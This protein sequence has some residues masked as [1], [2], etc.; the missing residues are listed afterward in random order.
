VRRWRE[1]CGL[2]GVDLGGVAE[3]PPLTL[4]RGEFVEPVLS[5]T[6]GGGFEEPLTPPDT[7]NEVTTMGNITSSPLSSETSLSLSLGETDIIMTSGGDDDVYCL[8]PDFFYNVEDMTIDPN[9]L[10]M[11]MTPAFLNNNNDNSSP[12]SSSVE[13]ILHFGDDAPLFLE[14]EGLVDGTILPMT[15]EKDLETWD[16]ELTEENSPLF[17]ELFTQEMF[18]GITPQDFLFNTAECIAH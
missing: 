17:D 16:Q 6:V 11:V 1:L 15:W 8:P 14:M 12:S 18:D 4:S 10:E 2:V 9:L 13:D 5:S 3:P 7:M